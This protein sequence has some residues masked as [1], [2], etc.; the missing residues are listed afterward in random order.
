MPAG[1]VV[2]HAVLQGLVGCSQ[3]QWGYTLQCAFRDPQV[4][5]DHL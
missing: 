5:A 3:Q 1:A 4:D 2:R